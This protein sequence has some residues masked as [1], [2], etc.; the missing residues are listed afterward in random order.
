MSIDAN[1]DIQCWTTLYSAVHY[2][3]LF[4]SIVHL[5]SVSWSK[6]HSC[7]ENTA[8]ITNIPGSAHFKDSTFLSSVFNFQP[9][10]WCN[11]DDCKQ[12]Q[13]I[14]SILKFLHFSFCIRPTFY[15]LLLCA[16][17][18]AQQESNNVFCI[19]EANTG[20]CIR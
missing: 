6:N 2:C 9:Y 15:T 18:Y 20:S 17:Y 12:K 16:I 3:T 10:L 1:V 4:H 14:F 13:Q 5:S 7:K 19:S 8:Q 11:K